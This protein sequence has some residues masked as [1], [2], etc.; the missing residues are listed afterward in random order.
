MCFVARNSDAINKIRKKVNFNFYYSI[1][2]QQINLSCNDNGMY[3]G[4]HP[5]LKEV[6]FT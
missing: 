1:N 2:N 4:T 6:P 3:S 5:S